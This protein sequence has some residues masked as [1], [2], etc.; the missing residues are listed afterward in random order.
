MV[1]SST[2][3]LWCKAEQKLP[4]VSYV[5]RHCG[6]LLVGPPSRATP[7]VTVHHQVAAVGGI[8]YKAR[9]LFSRRFRI[10]LD[11]EMVSQSSQSTALGRGVWALPPALG[12]LGSGSEFE[13]SARSTAGKMAPC[14]L[15]VLPLFLSSSVERTL[16]G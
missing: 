3:K 6:F 5:T 8:Q 1:V 16:Q 15:T 4:S 13:R 7:S 11:T 14:P 9:Y 2:L 10:P 12:N